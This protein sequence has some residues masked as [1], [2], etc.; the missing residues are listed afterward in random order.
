MSGEISY[1][2][3][4]KVDE[5]DG[6]QRFNYPLLSTP[7]RILNNNTNQIHNGQIVLPNPLPLQNI[8][9]VATPLRQSNPR[10]FDALNPNIPV[11]SVD[12]VLSYLNQV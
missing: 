9:R 12:Q 2:T 11:Q 4:M 3:E 7:T 10:V 1:D 8:R 6:C 5:D